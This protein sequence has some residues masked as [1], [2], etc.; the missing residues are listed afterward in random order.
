MTPAD[1]GSADGAKLFS[2]T[3]GGGPGGMEQLTPEQYRA[4]LTLG[5][6]GQS[7]S[8][9]QGLLSQRNYGGVCQPSPGACQGTFHEESHFLLTTKPPHTKFPKEKST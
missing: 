1:L 8:S 3:A 7:H 9:T 4:A 2:F 5:K 6:V